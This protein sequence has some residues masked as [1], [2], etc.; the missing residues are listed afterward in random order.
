VTPTPKKRRGARSEVK[1][2]D[3]ELRPYGYAPG[4]FKKWCAACEREYKG[5]AANAFKCRP[6]AAN[7]FADVDALCKA[8]FGADK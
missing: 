1:A 5:L 4:E 8:R 2:T 3:A 7:Q 6:C